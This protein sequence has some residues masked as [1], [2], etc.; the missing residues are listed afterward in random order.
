MHAAPPPSLGPRIQELGDTLVVTFRPRRSW[1]EVLFLSFWLAFW[2]FGG[3]AAMYALAGAG[4]GVRV[5]LLLWLCGWAFGEAFAAMQI[6]WQLNGREFLTVTANQLEVRQ[7]VGRFDRTRRLHVLAVYDV[8]PERV[9]SDEDEQPRTDYRLR[10]VS[11][12]GSLHAGEDMSEQEAEYVASVVR[13]QI[14]P[15]PRW[16]DDAGEYGFAPTAEAQPATS[17]EPPLLDGPARRFDSSWVIA[18][19]VPAIVGLAAIAFV[20]AAALPP[21]RHPPQLPRLRPPPPPV[22][23]SPAVERRTGG[24]PLRQEFHVPRA[25]AI[26]MTRY[27]LRG[28]RTKVESKPRCGK[29]VTWTHWTCRARATSRLGPFAGRSLT[30]RCSV[31]AEAEPAEAPGQT[32]LCGPEHP[33]PM[34]P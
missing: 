14:K 11:R 16:S 28:A 5:F 4:P 13:S 7:Q 19:V 1:G 21:L 34:T 9:P 12:D 17:S 30:Y 22:Q 33:P 31:E 10:I 25:Y 6:A 26:A 2:T 27:A 32:I 3:L 8:V 29:K 23:S 20:V 15:R 18:R 24:P